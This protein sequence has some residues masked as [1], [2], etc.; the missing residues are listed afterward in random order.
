MIRFRNP[1]CLPCHSSPR[2]V[3]VGGLPCVFCIISQNRDFVKNFFRS[4]ASGTFC[5]T[6]SLKLSRPRLD[7]LPVVT[8][9]PLLD[10]VGI[11]PHLFGFVKHYF[12]FRRK[13]FLMHPEGMRSPLGRIFPTSPDR[14]TV[15]FLVRLFQHGGLF[16]FFAH[17]CKGLFC[18][19][20][21]P[22]FTVSASSAR[23]PLV[24]LTVG[25]M[26][27]FICLGF[28]QWTSISSPNERMQVVCGFVGA[29]RLDR[30]TDGGWR[31]GSPLPC[32]V[33]CILP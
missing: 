9:K 18:A 26:A 4:V 14:Y 21:V 17:W 16:R 6:V 32:S 7:A 20:L 29:S 30:E 3:A 25:V 2:Y 27:L 19:S 22:T 33:F 10:C 1:H 11:V 31:G 8:G 5:G 15:G 12:C 28:P 13:W 24:A 23:V